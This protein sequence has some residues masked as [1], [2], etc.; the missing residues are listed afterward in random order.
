MYR[1]RFVIHGGIDGYSR[2]P[3]FCKCSGNNRAATVLESFRD[4]VQQFGLPSRVRSDKGMENIDVARFMLE[5]RGTG[6]GSMITGRSVHNQR[7][8]RFWRDLFQ[9]CTFLF[10]YL[11]YNLEESCLLDPTEERDLFCLHY[12][13]QARINFAIEQFCS[14]YRNHR[15]RSAANRTPLQLWIAGMFRGKGPATID[16]T[17][18]VT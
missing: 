13:Y 17:N 14:G 7:I 5:H 12:V 16:N 11:F 9:G 15:I 6:R 4:A 1:W 8:E 18:M 3:V 10:Y 2:V